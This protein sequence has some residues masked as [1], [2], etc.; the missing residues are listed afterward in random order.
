MQKFYCAICK[1]ERETDSHVVGS[2]DGLQSFRVCNEHIPEQHLADNNPN[3]HDGTLRELIFEN[4]KLVEI[5]LP[6]PNAEPAPQPKFQGLL[7]QRK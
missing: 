2:R 5:E 4:D 1:E 7:D 3:H 6:E